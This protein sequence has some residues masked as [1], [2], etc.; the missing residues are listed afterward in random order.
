MWVSRPIFLNALLCAVDYLPAGGSVFAYYLRDLGI[1]KVKHLVQQKGG[2]LFG[3]QT[4]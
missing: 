4:L 2:S 1:V 3:C